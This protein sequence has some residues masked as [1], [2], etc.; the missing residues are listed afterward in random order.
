MLKDAD[1]GDYDHLARFGEWEVTDEPVA[2]I[3]T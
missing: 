2:L 3:L 1:R